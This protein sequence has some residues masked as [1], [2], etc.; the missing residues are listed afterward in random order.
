M[1]PAL[2]LDRDGIVNEVVRR[3]A[4]IG[5]P[6]SVQELTI[7]DE[8]KF[9]V[10][11]ARKKGFFVGVVT[12]QPDVARRKMYFND[13]EKINLK[14]LKEVPVDEIQVCTSGDDRDYRKKPNPGMLYELSNVHDL[15]LDGSYIIGDGIHDVEAGR[16]A[17]VKTILLCTDYNQEYHGAAD[18][19]FHLLSEIVDFISDLDTK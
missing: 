10:E 8:S 19:N 6:R 9:L 17:G 5:Q 13:M 7:V 18:H 2:F 15:D 14:I 3:G 12:N 1:K 4:E 11:T 16:R